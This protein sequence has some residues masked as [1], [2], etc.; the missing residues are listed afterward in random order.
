MATEGNDRDPKGPEGGNVILVVE[1]DP[2]VLATTAAL[3]R[4]MG[5]EVLEAANVQAALDILGSAPRIDLLFTD[6]VMP[7]G[8]NGHELAVRARQRQPSLK[9]LFT[10]GYADDAFVDE[11]V[12][13]RGAGLISKPFTMKALQEKIDQVFDGE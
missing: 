6:V 10:S 13:S 3:I 4:R 12:N 8:M 5:F 7:G 11:D 9:V 1:D 2:L